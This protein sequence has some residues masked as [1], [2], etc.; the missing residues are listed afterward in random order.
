MKPHSTRAIYVMGASLDHVGSCP[1]AKFDEADEQMLSKLSR[2]DEEMAVENLGKLLEDAHVSQALADSGRAKPVVIWAISALAEQAVKMGIDYRALRLGWHHPRTR[3]EYQAAIH[4]S[5]THKSSRRRSE[6][7]KRA[8]LKMVQ[9]IIAADVQADVALCN[10]FMQEIGCQTSLC[11]A[12]FAGCAAALKSE[13]LLPLRALNEGIE[14]MTTTTFGDP[15]PEDQIRGTVLAITSSVVSSANSFAEW[16]YSNDIGQEQLR[17]LTMRQLELWQEPTELDHANGVRTH[18][19]APGEHGLFWATKI[20][21][22]SH[23]F[24]YEG[25]CLLPLLSNARHK[26]VLVSDPQ[27]PDYP[28]GRAH[29]RLLWSV[30]SHKASTAPPQPRLF[31]EGLHKDFSAVEARINTSGWLRALVLHAV[32]KADAMRVALSLDIELTDLLRHVTTFDDSSSGEVLQIAECMLLRPSNG[33]VEASDF[34]S[35][36]HDW[37]QNEAEVTEP[38]WRVLYRPNVK[39]DE[40]LIRERS[41]RQ[42][43]NGL[44]LSALLRGHGACTRF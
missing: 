6:E 4:P 14:C 36:K 29:W 44:S 32:A 34:L 18:E 25:Q 12:R 19:D 1:G 23:G 35:A 22:P 2:F 3:S 9:A 20:G 24:D 39:G 38:L 11:K 42:G 28:A 16:R 40:H 13:L 43:A 21:G 17:G 10:A 8:I 31:M 15:L 27:W 33:V 26:V 37:L 5:I 7:S 41:H 30:G